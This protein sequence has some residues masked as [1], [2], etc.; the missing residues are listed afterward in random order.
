MKVPHTSRLLID[1][2]TVLVTDSDDDTVIIT[3]SIGPLM[4]AFECEDLTGDETERTS[5]CGVD[6]GEDPALRVSDSLKTT[7][8]I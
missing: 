7:L 6:T 2:V 8:D 1:K 3:W 5:N 4:S